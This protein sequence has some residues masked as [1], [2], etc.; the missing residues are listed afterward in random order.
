[1][2]A[3]QKRRPMMKQSTDLH[4]SLPP[5]YGTVYLAPAEILLSFLLER[6][7]SPADALADADSWFAKASKPGNYVRACAIADS[8]EDLAETSQVHNA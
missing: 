1:M 8:F 6:K 3:T 2:T 5:R 7:P 4:V